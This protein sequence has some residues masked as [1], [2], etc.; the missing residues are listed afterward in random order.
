MADINEYDFGVERWDLVTMIYAGDDARWLKR[1][2]A[3]VRLGGLVVVEYFKKKSGEVGRGFGPGQLAA[4]FSGWEI[5]RNEVVQAKAD[6]GQRETE[7]VRF[8]ARAR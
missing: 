7:L 2:K 5:L 1:I 8:V 4:L 3:S 6:W